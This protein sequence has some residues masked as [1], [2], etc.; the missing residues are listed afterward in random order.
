MSF[1]KTSEIKLSQFDNDLPIPEVETPDYAQNDSTAKDYIKNRP[2]GY[3]EGW[4]ITWDGDTTGR[5]SINFDI[6]LYKVSD[7][8]LTK[9]QC[10]GALAQITDG[11]GASEQITIPEDYCIET[12]DFVFCEYIIVF[13][14]SGDITFNS[15]TLTVP[16]PG[17]YFM[18][19]SRVY[20]SS[21]S[22]ISVYPF[23]DKYIPN[24]I[25]RKAELDARITDKEVVL[26]S[27]T[28]GSSKKFKI[29]VDDSGA[30]T[31]T[32]ITDTTSGGV[33]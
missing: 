18:N 19:N 10:G 21:L 11:N 14:K 26:A 30:I 29:T 4:E 25:A 9:E 6:A 23:P 12:D 27:S 31:A 33:N 7:V 1:K 13:K 16:E 20:I 15:S 32:E 24:T 28:D 2:G 17:V 5:A 8:I 3:E 22:N